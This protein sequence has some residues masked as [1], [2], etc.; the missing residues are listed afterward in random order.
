MIVIRSA[1]F[2]VYFF[3][4]TFVVTIAATVARLISAERVLGYAIVWAQLILWGLRTIC[5]IRV[6]VSGRENIPEGAALIASAHQSAFDT[7]VWLTLV[8]RAC[9]VFKQELLRIPLFGHLVVAAG[10]IPIDR[11][12]GAA[13]MRS[14][15]RAGERAKGEARQIII[16]PEGTRAPPDQPLPLQSGV[17]ALA[18]RTGLPVVP[19]ATD[20]GRYWG[21]R[22]FQK[23]PGTIHV[24]VRPALPANLRRGELM[25]QLEQALRLDG[26]V[27][28][29]T[30]ISVENSVGSIATGR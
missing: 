2:N 3:A 12:S 17:A 13:A 5:G 11:S 20:S 23:R 22:A 18:I 28:R 15:L 27:S 7:I 9:Y 29:R 1:V 10:M 6:E 30:D 25:A 24:M 4:A 8:P 21:R 16:F 19:V 26:P 14:L